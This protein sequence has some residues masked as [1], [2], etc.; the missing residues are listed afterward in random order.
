MTY[1]VRIGVRLDWHWTVCTDIWVELR[2]Q[3]IS[4]TQILNR[5]PQN[6]ATPY[7]FDSVHSTALKFR[8]HAVAVLIL[9]IMIAY[10]T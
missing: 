8:Q 2:N 3:M 9:R 6:P 5:V 7:P 10:S 4:A 1:S